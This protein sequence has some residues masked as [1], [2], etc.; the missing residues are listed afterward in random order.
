MINQERDTQNNDRSRIQTIDHLR[1][2]NKSTIDFLDTFREQSNLNSKKEL[3]Q[4]MNM[5]RR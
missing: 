1:N 5:E 2:F 3:N 4:V